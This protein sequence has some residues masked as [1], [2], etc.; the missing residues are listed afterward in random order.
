MHTG[1][2]LTRTNSLP[3]NVHKFMTAYYYYYYYYYYRTKSTLR[4]NEEQIAYKNNAVRT[5]YRATVQSVEIISLI[6]DS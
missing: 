5:S 4:T 1:N 6:S 3:Q 2:L